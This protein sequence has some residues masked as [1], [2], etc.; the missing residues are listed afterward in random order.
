M[1]FSFGRDVNILWKHGVNA[2]SDEEQERDGRGRVSIIL[3]G[4]VTDTREEDGSPPMLPYNDHGKGGGHDRHRDHKR[5]QGRR[6]GGDDDRRRERDRSRDRGNGDRERERDGDRRGEASHG[7]E[8]DSRQ[9]YGYGSSRADYSSRRDHREGEE[10]SDRDAS[11][12]VCRDF[13]RGHCRFGDRCRFE[14]GSR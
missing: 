9:D 8:R 11:R 1:L 3:W 2:L 13:V 10:R 14:H 4:L 12:Q 5:E 7:G 6:D